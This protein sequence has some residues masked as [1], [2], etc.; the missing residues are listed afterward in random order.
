M[1]QN[2]VLGSGKWFGTD[3]DHNGCIR[4][5]FGQTKKMMSK[6]SFWGDFAP[7]FLYGMVL[8]SGVGTGRKLREVF[9][10]IKQ[11]RFQN[12]KMMS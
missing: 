11:E 3:L 4:S 7:K 1:V 5:D 8:S 9:K 10:S 2:H 6:K 12:T